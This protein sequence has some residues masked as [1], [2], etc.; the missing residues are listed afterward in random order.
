M[1][2]IL[3]YL[4]EGDLRSISKVDQLVEQIT[5]QAD[6][7]VLFKYLQT[8]DRLVVMRT[9]DA[10]EKITRQ[11]PQFLVVH[12]KAYFS[13][14]TKAK[15]KELKWHLAQLAA[16]FSYSSEELEVIW[17]RLQ[18]W[19]TD[20]KESKIV[21]VNAVQALFD[22]S[23]IDLSRRPQFQKMAQILKS[24]GVPSID[25]RLRKLNILG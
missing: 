6:F 23:L 10:V 22:L 19:A 11:N 2:D 15:N 24:E 20:K 5:T 8:D 7:D 1:N 9:A 21:R 17:Q 18:K 13:L 16:R 12:K 3:S 14:L 4:I 25:A